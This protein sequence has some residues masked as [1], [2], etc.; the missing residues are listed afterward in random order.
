M[1]DTE[2]NHLND[3]YLLTGLGSKGLVWAP[4]LA[5]YLADV[6]SGQPHCLPAPLSKRLETGRLYRT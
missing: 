1:R 5:E 2:G 3:L 6:I 4:L